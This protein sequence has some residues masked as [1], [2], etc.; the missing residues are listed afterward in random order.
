M[1]EF[2]ITRENNGQARIENDYTR[3]DNFDRDYFSVSG[4]WG[5]H[6]P[7]MFAASP[8]M[9]R[10][11]KYVLDAHTYDGALTMGTAALSPAIADLIKRTIAE[12]EGGE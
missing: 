12:A 11:L 3:L 5:V 4:Y 2:I 9:L 10:V 8:E 1:T 7:E 6:S